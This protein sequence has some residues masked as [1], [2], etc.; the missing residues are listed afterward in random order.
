MKILVSIVV[1]TYKRPD[2]LSR[3]MAALISQEFDPSAF[4]IIIVDDA[5]ENSTKNLVEAWAQKAVAYSFQPGRSL[6]VASSS[7]PANLHE[8][9]EPAPG[10]LVKI[11][12][13]PIVRYIPMLAEHGPAAAR[14]VGWLAAAG[15]IIA[16]T[17]DDCFP[18]PGWLKGGISAFDENTMGVCGKVIMPIPLVPT[19]YERD[20]SSLERSEFVTANCF[21]RRS[22]LEAAGGFDT[23]F[24]LAWREDSDVY[25]TL[26]ENNCLLRRTTDA[27][28]V[29]PIRPVRFG[30]SIPQQKKSMYNALLYKK[31]PHLYRQKVQKSPPVRY[32]LILL[33]LIVILSGLLT[34][35]RWSLS[36]GGVAWVA[37]TL[38][39]CFDRLKGTSHAPRHVL[40]MAATS[41]VIPILSIYWRLQ[42]AVRFRVLFF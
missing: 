37:L 31:H 36:A 40:E 19:D 2:L 12:G 14:N 23:R 33:S 8:E 41:T 27:I 13:I 29:H 10:R 26:L 32:Y 11:N 24:R 18:S 34:G 3:C 9:I 21:Y 20:A 42:G 7:N 38:R 30:V 16:F 5:A 6:T 39:F 28:V 15:E 17:D 22:A 25:F 1:P 35:N 4:E